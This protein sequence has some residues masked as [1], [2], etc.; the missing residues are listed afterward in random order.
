[1]S[2]NQIAIVEPTLA[3]AEAKAQLNTE[4]VE[5][6]SDVNEDDCVAIPVK[7]LRALVAVIDDLVDCD[8]VCEDGLFAI[9]YAKSLI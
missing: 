2:E 9:K 7:H 4:P 5:V 8:A 6:S 3:P 1:M